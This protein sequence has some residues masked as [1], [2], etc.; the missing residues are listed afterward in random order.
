[1]EPQEES[2]ATFSLFQVYSLRGV[3]WVLCC[4]LGFF[5]RRAKYYF[6]D[7]KGGLYDQLIHVRC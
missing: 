5:L 3:F 6:S 7:K 2:A 1:M 4:F